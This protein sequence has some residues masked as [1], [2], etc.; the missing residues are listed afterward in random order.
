MKLYHILVSA[1][2]LLLFL[3]ISTTSAIVEIGGKE[4]SQ[5]REFYQLITY[6]VA[7]DDQMQQT[8]TYVKNAFL[9]ALRRFKIGPVGVFKT[10]ATNDSIHKIIVLIPFNSLGQFHSLEEALQQDKIYVQTSSSYA[11]ATYD[12]PAYER[13]ESVLMQAFKEMPMLKP[14]SLQ[15]ERAKRVYELRS[16]ESPSEKYFKNKVEMFNEGGEIALFERLHFNAVFYGE[17]LVGSHMPNLMYL[18]TFSNMQSREEHWKAFGEAPEWKV[19][20]DLPKYQNNVSHMD[21]TFLYP[22]DYSDY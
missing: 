7:T 4:N 17:V 18:T 10:I 22:T 16:Y 11:N 12:K 8:E 5:T 13:M 9:P 6:S 1:F 2:F 15:G 14:P 3:N 20:K 19:L 21:I